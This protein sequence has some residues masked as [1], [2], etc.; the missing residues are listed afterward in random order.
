MSNKRPCKNGKHET[1]FYLKLKK[2]VSRLPYAGDDL[3]KKK[4]WVFGPGVKGGFNLRQ[5]N[6]R[7]PK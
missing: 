6:D 7:I 4:Q 3:A 1:A 2:I 5:N